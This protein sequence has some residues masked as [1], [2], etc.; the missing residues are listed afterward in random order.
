MKKNILY[1]LLLP[2]FS[3]C[4][5]NQEQRVI[6]LI[7]EPVE[8]TTGKG[9]FELI[10]QTVINY[11]K[12]DLDDAAGYLADCIA[13]ETG[14]RISVEEGNASI[15]SI[16]LDYSL[17]EDEKEDAYQLQA[18]EKRVSIHGANPR[19]VMLGIQTLRQLISPEPGNT[20]LI[21][22]VQISD[23]SA[24]QWRGMMMDAA[25]HFF[26]KEEVKE[27]LDLMA[28]YKFNKFHWHITDDQGWRVEIKKYPELIEK[29]A[30]REFNRHDKTCISQAEIE[31]N[32]DFLLPEDKLKKENG[33]I[34]YGGFY[35]QE[36]IKEIVAYASAL[37]IDVIPE[38]DIP[39]HSMCAIAA[40]PELSCFN[41]A[42][43]G[44]D[45]SSPLCPGKD[46]TLEMY[47]NIY[48]EIFELFPYEYVH[49]GADEV[50]KINWKKCPH[51][52]ARIKKEN[53]KDEQELQAWFVR[54]MEQF[55]TENG[56][57]LIGWD[58]IVD[59]GL[60]PDATVMWWRTWV[61][62]A[63]KRVMD[64]GNKVIL[65]PNSHYY[66]DYK[67]SSKTLQELYEFDPVSSDV[68]ELKNLIL[69]IQANSWAEAIPSRER[70]HYLI[71]PRMLALSE[72]AW[73][74]DPQ[75]T[76]EEFYPRLVSH[77]SHLDR[78]KVN[79]RPLGIPD[80]HERN[81]FVG[82]TNVE[83]K[84]PLPGVELRYT[85]DGTVPTHNSTLYTGPFPLDTTTHFMIRMFRPDQSA[86]D[87][88]RTI[89]T[90]G[91]YRAGTENIK[92][93]G[94]LACF[95]HEG[96]FNRCD[97]IETVPVKENYTVESITVPK[98][99]GG[100]RGL[101]Y[102][103][104]LYVSEKDI[105]A[106]YLGSDDGSQLYVYDD[107]TVDNDSPHGPVTLSA[108]VA[109]D[110]GLHPVKIYYFDMNNGGFIDL[111][112]FNSKGMKINLDAKS[113]RH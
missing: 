76:W 44:V 107:L 100:K 39:G 67:Q 8:I 73:R 102:K 90:R 78:M 111:K 34:L 64:Q 96:L 16:L 75:R 66:F 109:L 53:L 72:V 14:I 69:G 26:N 2:I 81:V 46:N 50:E 51:C 45:F 86:A 63:P 59:G 10:S 25:R 20:A 4:N 93:T 9:N 30:W 61:P 113:L 58:E 110:K 57:K 35:T 12:P 1:L 68:K 108:Q 11:N 32:K 31:H 56:K 55:F 49:L 27:F 106:F 3:Y 29:G 70:L 62:N 112:L 18:N 23:R 89:Y 87:I 74:Y 94:G 38:I 40:Y 41:S 84:Y 52:Q 92:T 98:G 91:E 19:S 71:A 42:G 15:N 6:H 48:A 43:W 85:T 103:G 83:W 21:P 65:A 79:Y 104:Y 82:K 17:T 47:K 105:Y 54:Q 101:V 7:P 36:D 77:F 97:Q 88:V 22:C 5:K 28:Y 24:W 95:W 13:K 60:S 33:K 80:I 99:V 37:G